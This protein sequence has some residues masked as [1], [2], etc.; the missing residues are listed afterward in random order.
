MHKCR[1]GKQVLWLAG[2]PQVRKQIQ[3]FKGRVSEA[4]VITA[5]AS[6]FLLVVDCKLWLTLCRVHN[7]I[8]CLQSSLAKHMRMPPCDTNF[9]SHL[10]LD[11]STMGLC[12]PCVETVLVSYLLQF[13]LTNVIACATS[14][15]VVSLRTTLMG[16]PTDSVWTPNSNCMFP[17]FYRRP[18]EESFLLESISMY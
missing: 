15:W 10:L 5:T 7:R 16:C 13:F 4:H 11:A 17:R 1:Q 3:S 18:W 6:T 12:V 9:E 2:L 8:I 14:E